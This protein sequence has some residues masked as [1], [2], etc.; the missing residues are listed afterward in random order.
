[1]LV[2]VSHLVTPR[3]GGS[4]RG[5][6]TQTAILSEGI[7]EQLLPCV[8][9]EGWESHG[10]AVCACWKPPGSRR[11]QIE[12]GIHTL[13]QVLTEEFLSSL[14]AP[15]SITAAP[16]FTGLSFHSFVSAESSHAHVTL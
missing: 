16:A 2:P 5:H 12:P 4:S 1:M 14:S 13:Q 9:A 7:D 11:S 8:L 6:S 10:T 3:S 15:A